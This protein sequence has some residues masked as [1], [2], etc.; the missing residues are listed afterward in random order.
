MWV[1][2]PLLKEEVNADSARTAIDHQVKPGSHRG[3]RDL[4]NR[5]HCPLVS[6]YG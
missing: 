1:K 5:S 6:Y 4:G 3:I 2:V